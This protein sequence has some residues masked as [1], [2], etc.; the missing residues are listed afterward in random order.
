MDVSGEHTADTLNGTFTGSP[1]VFCFLPLCRKLRR[2][3][4]FS[5]V[6]TVP[7]MILQ[8]LKIHFPDLDWMQSM[9]VAQI[10]FSEVRYQSRTYE[11]G[12]NRTSC[13]T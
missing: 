13:F 12:F 2:V 11:S 9:I 8:M 6:S 5:R 4:K 7:R 3:A 1:V 10:N